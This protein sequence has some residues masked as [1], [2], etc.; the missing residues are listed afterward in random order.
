[1]RPFR[2][3]IWRLLRLDPIALKLAFFAYWPL[4]AK[5]RHEAFDLLREVF[6][7]HTSPDAILAEESELREQNAQSR[8]SVAS[9]SRNSNGLK[10]WDERDSRVDLSLFYGTVPT[11]VLSADQ[12]FLD[13]NPGFQ[14]I[15]GSLEGIRRGGHVSNWFNH[16]DN[17]RRIPKRSEAL[18]GEGILPIA[19]RER[20]THISPQFVRMVFVKIMTPI[21]D[22]KTGRIIGWTVALNI[23]SV[24]LRHEFFEAFFRA[25]SEEARLIRYASAVDGLFEDFADRRALLAAHADQVAGCIRV[26]DIG[27]RTGS[28]AKVLLQNGHKVT[29]VEEDVHQLR[30]LRDKCEGFDSRMRAVR[31]TLSSLKNLPESRF[32]AV[33][34]VDSLES[35]GDLSE[36]FGKVHSCLRTGGTL[37]LSLRVGDVES[38]FASLRN[39]LEATG[40]FDSLKHQV[41]QVKDHETIEYGRLP[42][43]DPV[44]VVEAIRYGGLVVES[45]PGSPISAV[46][47]PI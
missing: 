27:A 11:F 3:R 16:L 30:V 2:V 19:D 42:R 31:Q 37:S 44:H 23:N 39:V 14:L 29:A 7:G 1:M 22:R 13:W 38:I 41:T 8:S 40:K 21:V 20:V 10:L 43:V 28:F 26:L 4:I 36:F 9:A 18:Y 25:T 24:N 45:D 17:F 47:Q 46:W 5:K 33:T 12:R 32:D 34:V 35:V 6:E 15:F